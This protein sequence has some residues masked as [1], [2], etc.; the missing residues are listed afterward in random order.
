MALAAGLANGAGA[1]SIATGIVLNKFLQEDMGEEC[2][3]KSARLQDAR[4]GVNP[5]GPLKPSL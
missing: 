2:R 5:S 1:C 3:N 4:A